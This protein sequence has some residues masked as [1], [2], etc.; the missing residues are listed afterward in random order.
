MPTSSNKL[1]IIIIRQTA[2]RLIQLN[3]ILIVHS[4]FIVSKDITFPYLYNCL[5]K[6]KYIYPPTSSINTLRNLINLKYI[7]L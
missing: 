5:S 7:K 1:I 3:N 2:H 4:V 6:L